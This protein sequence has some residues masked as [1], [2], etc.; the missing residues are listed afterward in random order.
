M[1]SWRCTD[2]AGLPVT[3]RPPLGTCANCVMSRSI[4][5]ASRTS[6][7]STSTPSAG[8]T[9]WIAPNWP[10][11]VANGRF[12]KLGHALYGGRNLFE[13]LQ[14][15]PAHGIFEVCHARYIATWV[16]QAIDE[17]R[18]DRLGDER[19]DNRNGT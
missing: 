7:G 13:Q 9:A 8:A 1:M 18:S 14:P 12:A 16:G 11:P 2:A 15:F 6:I 10:G 4:S 17:T 19:K 3:I 5:P